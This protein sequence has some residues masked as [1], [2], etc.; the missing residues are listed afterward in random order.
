[1]KREHED[2]STDQ[3]EDNELSQTQDETKNLLNNQDGDNHHEDTSIQ[4]QSNFSS[5]NDQ[6]EEALSNQTTNQDFNE[7]STAKRQKRSDDEEIRLL[8]PSKV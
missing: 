5:S 6:N 7:G 1:M 8:I 4:E 3:P 2:D